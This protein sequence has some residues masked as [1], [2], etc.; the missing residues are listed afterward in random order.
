M[1]TVYGDYVNI[2]TDTHSRFKSTPRN[3][4]KALV[5]HT[6]LNVLMWKDNN[7]AAVSHS[8]K[9]FETWPVKIKRC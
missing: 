4:N 9:I 2:K 3:L 6:E 7:D 1:A 8:Q 5:M